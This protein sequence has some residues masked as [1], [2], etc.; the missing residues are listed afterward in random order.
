MSIVDGIGEWRQNESNELSQQIE[1]ELNNLQNPK[2][3]SQAKKIICSMKTCGFG[4]QMHHVLYCFLVAYATNRTL[5][6]NSKG[7]SYNNNGLDVYFKPLSQSC[8]SFE[9]D[10]IEWGKIIFVKYF[11]RLHMLVS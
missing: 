8:K 3:C 5:I 9:G 6:V 4:C 7:W 1:R 10:V 2:D 11:L